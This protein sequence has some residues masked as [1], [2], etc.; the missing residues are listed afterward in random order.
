MADGGGGIL[1]IEEYVYYYNVRLH[2]KSIFYFLLNLSPVTIW[3]LA[4]VGDYE[5]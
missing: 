2:S 1:G 5:L 3:P 4:V